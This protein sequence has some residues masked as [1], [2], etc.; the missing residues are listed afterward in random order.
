MTTHVTGLASSAAVK[1]HT[2]DM[3]GPIAALAIPKPALSILN[4]VTA[5]V[6][7]R[8]TPPTTVITAP[9][10]VR[11]PPRPRTMSIMTLTSSWF[12]SI[13]EAVFERIVSPTPMRSLTVGRS[14]FPID[15]L[16]FWMRWFRRSYRSGS[17][18]LIAFAIP[19]ATL[20]PEP[21]ASYMSRMLPCRSSV[22]S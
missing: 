6:M 21:R 3:S 19:V 18:S 12:C 13:H 15:S 20:A 11:N 5:F 16:T 8:P 7:T 17:V 22:L 10:T 4:A 1:L 2:L 14:M 9:P